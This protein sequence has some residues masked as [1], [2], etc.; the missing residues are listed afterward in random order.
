MLADRIHPMSLSRRNARS[1][2]TLALVCTVACSD[3]TVPPAPPPPEPPGFSTLSV[4]PASAFAGERVKLVAEPP[5]ALGGLEFQIGGQRVVADR[6]T[7]EVEVPFFENACRREL[8]V[9]A[10]DPELLLK[11]ATLTW[12]GPGHPG[13]PRPRLAREVPVRFS[14]NQIYPV[15]GGVIASAFGSVLA[16]VGGDQTIR[17]ASHIGDFVEAFDVH[18]S[19]AAPRVF[20]MGRHGGFGVIEGSGRS[21]GGLYDPEIAL[22]GAPAVQVA[23]PSA[24]Y[25][26]PTSFVMS[27]ADNG[28]VGVALGQLGDVTP[29]RVVYR[30]RAGE[31]PLLETG[32][33][34]RADELVLRAPRLANAGSGLYALAVAG[35]PA[36]EILEAN[37]ASKPLTVSLG[38]GSA[39]PVALS[40]KVGRDPSSMDCTY[41]ASVWRG[42][43][44]Q[45][46]RGSGT[47][48]ATVSFERGGLVLVAN[49]VGGTPSAQVIS[50]ELFDHVALTW[51][52]A[53]TGQGSA[54]ELVAANEESPLL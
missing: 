49:P 12:L 47:K 7:G 30:S 51:I 44:N 28:A 29:Q 20:Y 22:P 16:T 14:P 32:P 45:D 50:T 8:L 27:P 25:S 11:P 35:T 3:F 53:L 33:H 23:L 6:E 2:A 5:M 13:R 43:L 24:I 52:P 18:P 21:A 46:P 26:G 42:D 1:L 37:E 48:T 19:K 41:V 15:Q 9:E 38:T 54:L 31:L 34:P 40:A 10:A 36:L 17:E 4:Q 39:V